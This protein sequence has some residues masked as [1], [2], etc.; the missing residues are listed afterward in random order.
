ML[1]NQQTD[2]SGDEPNAE[3]LFKVVAFEIEV[4][5]HHPGYVQNFAKAWVDHN[6]PATLEFVVT[7]LFYAQ[8]PD[9]VNTVQNIASDRVTIRSITEAEFQHMQKFPLLRY[10]K[11]WNLFCNYLDKL[12]A[13]HG[14]VMY[15]D[16][17]QLPTVIGRKC[18]RPYSAIYFRPTFHYH[19]L[20]NYR[21][22]LADR[23]R[24][25][26][27]KLLLTQVLKNTE[28]KQLYCLDE[29]A[30][31]HMQQHLD[32]TVTH[33]HIA[34][35]FT[36]YQTSEPRQ[37]QLRNQLQIEPDR[38]VFLLLGVLDRRKGV[39][40]LLQ[41]LSLVPS[42]AGTKMC[43]VLAGKIADYQ[44]EEIKN[45]VDDLGRQS[46]IQVILHDEYIQDNQ[47]QHYYDLSDVILATYQKHMGSS[48]A[49]IRAALAQKPVL[50]SDYGLMG[51]IVRNRQLGITVD[52]ASP[53]AIANGLS[54]FIE[55]PDKMLNKG[56]AAKYAAENSP[57][58]LAKDLSQMIAIAPDRALATQPQ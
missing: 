29:I 2:L 45:I 30:V 42:P 31:Q 39:K 53:K 36:I 32:S 17:F 56:N 55:Q 11:A 22:T 44:R 12:N 25:F 33:R 48:S 27:K 5:G 40:E 34:D 41:S 18:S 16:Y 47:V 46:D 23:F 7:P 26:R 54:A 6:I 43:I 38:T 9:T 3:G 14:L 57:R 1:P 51:E 10:F 20:P 35:S 58:Q 15:Y 28:L 8:H 24:N 52:T 13:S 4:E 49:L 50:S 19:K 21:P 37:N